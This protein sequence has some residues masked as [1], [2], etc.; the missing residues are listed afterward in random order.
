MS[1]GDFGR[2]GNNIIIDDGCVSDLAGQVGAS[3]ANN[4]I[5]V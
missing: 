1:E 2:R 4:S 3:G 5:V